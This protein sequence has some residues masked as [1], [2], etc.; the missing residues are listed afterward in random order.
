MRG[1]HRCGRGVPA[2]V[3]SVQLIN[4]L[5]VD[6]SP[7]VKTMYWSACVSPIME[8]KV[9]EK[10]REVSFIGVLLRDALKM[11]TNSVG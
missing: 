6:S 3:T 9:L 8:W 1:L 4:E 7:W 5:Q 11:D 2:S 10:K